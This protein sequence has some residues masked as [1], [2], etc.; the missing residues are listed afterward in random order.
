ME[1]HDGRSIAAAANFATDV[2]STN[3]SATGDATAVDAATS[4]AGPAIVAADGGSTGRNNR[5]QLPDAGTAA[6]DGAPTVISFCTSP[7]PGC[8]AISCPITARS[9]SLAATPRTTAI[10]P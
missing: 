8:S 4:D 6:V 9:L 1:Q 10:S 2:W 3:G 5:D 7:T